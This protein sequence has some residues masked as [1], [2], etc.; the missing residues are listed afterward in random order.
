MS[1]LPDQQEHAVD[2]ITDLMRPALRAEDFE[3]ERQVI[4]EEIAMYDD[5]PPYG[6]ME[7]C[8]EAFFGDHPLATRVLGTPHTVSELDPDA[9]RQYH[10][11][12]YARQS[13][14][15]RHWLRRFFGPGE[16]SRAAYPRVAPGCVS[17][18]VP[19]TSIAFECV[20][21]LRHPPAMQ[22]YTFELAAG[23]S[24][25]EPGRYAVRLM[26]T[27]MGDDSGSRLFW[28]LVDPGLAESAGM[29]AQEYDECGLIGLYLT[30]APEDAS[31]N[32]EC[33]NRWLVTRR[34]P[35]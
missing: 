18:P 2:L 32:W 27:I 28:S 25:H 26:A 29:F 19:T 24:R 21:E 8:M 13:L 7:R 5:S 9:M 1:V 15:G 23:V 3:T 4:L 11:Q 30:C 33:S 34:N 31:E 17:A 6:A 22:Q 20:L 10:Q 35:R 12:R 14:S 16:T